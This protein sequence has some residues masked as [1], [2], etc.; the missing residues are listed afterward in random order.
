[1]NATNHDMI[2]LACGLGSAILFVLAHVLLFRFSLVVNVLNWLIK[3]FTL[4][5][6]INLGL[7]FAL[8]GS[9]SDAAIAFALY[10]ILSF[11]YVVC[12]VGPYETSVRIRIVRE[13]A[14][15]AE[16]L[17]MKELRRRYDNKDILVVRLERLVLSKDLKVEDAKFKDNR[18]RSI[19]TLIT[20]LTTFLKNCYGVEA[21]S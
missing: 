7:S 13:L 16:G 2:V 15:C 1:M 20:A 8:A 4:L 3:A 14:K 6:L 19:F 11:S 17:A 21:T 5:A 10:G 9:V 18:G 12:F